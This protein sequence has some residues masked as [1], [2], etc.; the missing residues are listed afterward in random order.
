MNEQ[1]LTPKFTE[2]LAY[3]AIVHRGQLRKGTT[4]S[5]LGHLLGVTSIVIDSGGTETESIAAVLHDA[6]ED[7]GGQA[8]LEDIRK[9]FGDAVAR[10]V[11]A[12]SDSQTTDPN[13]KPPWKERKL[14]YIAHLSESTDVSVYLV[15]CGDKLHNAR[16][17]L[18]DYKVLGDELWSRF[19]PSAGRDGV[20]WYYTQMVETYR[21]GP[22]DAR[23]NGILDQLAETVAEL[24]KRVGLAA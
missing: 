22:P 1:E 6:V 9:C 20:L 18:S 13:K 8:R 21:G 19:N 5:Y 7:C 10:I 15:S 24:Y 11:G 2:A 16:A 12:C 14:E 17:I 3:A 23:R 4:G